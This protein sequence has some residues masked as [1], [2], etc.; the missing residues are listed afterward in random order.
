M[1][2]ILVTSDERLVGLLVLDRLGVSAQK[3]VPLSEIVDL[4]LEVVDVV[5]G[6]VAVRVV[7]A[8]NDGFIGVGLVGGGAVGVAGGGQGGAHEGGEGEEEAE[9]GLRRRRFR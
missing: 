2:L 1:R 8:Q 5:R 6:I 7:V 9:H 4:L 3:N